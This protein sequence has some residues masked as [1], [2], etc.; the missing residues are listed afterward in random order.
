M[1]SDTWEE[2][3]NSGVVEFSGFVTCKAFGAGVS[4]VVMVVAEETGVL[5]MLLASC[6]CLSLFFSLMNFFFKSE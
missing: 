4:V 6:V 2:V 1:L 3:D 5:V